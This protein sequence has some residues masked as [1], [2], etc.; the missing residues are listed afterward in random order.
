[1]NIDIQ[2]FKVI[3]KGRVLIVK[4]RPSPAELLRQRPFIGDERAF[5]LKEVLDPLGLTE[6]NVLLAWC[7]AEYGGEAELKKFI[8]ATNP[9]VLISVSD[10]TVFTKEKRSWNFP[11]IEDMRVAKSKF[12]GEL[13]R[14]LVAVRKRLDATAHRTAYSVQLVTKGATPTDEAITTPIHKASAEKQIVYGVVLDPY[15]VDTQDDWVPPSEIET[16]AHRFAKE[17][18]VIG[19]HHEEVAADA[20]L[21]ETFI[22]PYPSETD[23]EKAMRNEPHRA[24]AR[25]Y[26]NDIIHSGAWVLGV[27]LSDRLWKKYENGELGAFSIEGLGRR[28][29]T[30]E[31]EMPEVTFVELGEVGSVKTHRT[32]TKV[33]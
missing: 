12:E 3:G 25:Q 17:S 29:Q 7:D 33:V 16:T 13:L 14:K 15:Q 20:V 24:Y 2:P 8:D 1:M 6:D 9:A 4:G 22:E 21:V 30:T 31:A 28:I 5:L 11:T 32:D 19:L 18:R 26:G 23:R 27:Q 10:E